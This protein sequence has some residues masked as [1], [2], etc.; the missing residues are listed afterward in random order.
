[1]RLGCHVGIAGGVDK[2]VERAAERG[3]ETV[4]VFISNPRSWR[5]TRPSPETCERFRAGCAEE[6][7][8]PVFVHTIYLI[9]L[10]APDIEVYRRSANSLAENVEAAALLGAEGVVTHL[11]SHKGEGEDAGFYRVC[12]ALEQALAATP[13][14]PAILLETTAGAGHAVGTRFEHLGRI[15][16]AF[17]V[18]PRLGVCLDTCHLHAAGYELRTRDGLDRTLGEL[19]EALGLNRVR[20]VHANDSRGGLGSQKDRHEHIGQ[21]EIGLDGFR[22]LTRDP[23]LRELPWILETP[24]ISPERDRENISLLRS[25]AAD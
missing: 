13:G 5:H 7:I 2:A 19:D 15:L 8:H 18:E 20:L 10:A 6:G 11:G 17:P 21:G 22:I 16:A 1:M 25:L 9:N 24:A 14:G 3:C 23:C 12:T 4:Q